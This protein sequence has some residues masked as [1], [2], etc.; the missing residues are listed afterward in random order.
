MGDIA[1][2]IGLINWPA[3]NMPMNFE[4]STLGQERGHVGAHLEGNEKLKVSARIQIERIV[5][6]HRVEGEIALS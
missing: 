3:P 2:T 6:D 4:R 1:V 5:L